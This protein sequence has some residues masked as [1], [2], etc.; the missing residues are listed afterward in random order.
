M[1][2]SKQKDEEEEEEEEGE[3][4]AKGEESNYCTLA[5]HHVGSVGLALDFVCSPREAVSS[6]SLCNKRPLD[7]V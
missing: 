7:F 6:Q 3:E 2:G 1:V 4:D 5:E